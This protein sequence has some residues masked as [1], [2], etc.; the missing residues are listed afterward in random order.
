MS[1]NL[2]VGNLL[3]TGLGEIMSLFTHS[4]VDTRPATST[5]KSFEMAVVNLWLDVCLL[6]LV[7][8]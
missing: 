6:Q 7:K 2:I 1:M 3:V 5:F 8:C 4:T